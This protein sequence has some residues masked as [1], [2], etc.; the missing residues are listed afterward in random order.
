MKQH[1]IVMNGYRLVQSEHA[2]Q[3]QTDKVDKANGLRPSIYN[4][5]QAMPADKSKVYEGV[6]LYKDK[7]I[8]L[9]AG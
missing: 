4:L 1:L 9:P 8:H 6:L 5:Y 7:T 2:G 3:W